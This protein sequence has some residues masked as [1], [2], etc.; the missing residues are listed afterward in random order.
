MNKLIILTISFSLLTQCSSHWGN[1]KK[2]S[3]DK[4]SNLEVVGER[5]SGS[6][7][8]FFKYWYTQNIATATRDALS[9]APGATGLTDVE[10]KAESYY[11]YNRIVVSGIP[12]KETESTSNKKSKK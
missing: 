7:G 10:V 11:I 3:L 6:D 12:V 4:P 1:F 2:Y 5:V 8:S 9:K